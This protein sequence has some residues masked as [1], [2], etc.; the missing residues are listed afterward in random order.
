MT[1]ATTTICDPSG[2]VSEVAYNNRLCKIGMHSPYCELTLH[3][4]LISTCS[5]SPA[6]CRLQ[7]DP[8]SFTFDY[9]YWSFEGY[10]TDE[11]NTFRSIPQAAG[12]DRSSIIMAPGLSLSPAG[13]PYADQ[14]VY[15]GRTSTR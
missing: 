7:S 4:S 1:G 13:P 2:R 15:L 8:R 10:E 14:L 5:I 12:T 9:S 3:D 11:N 6:P